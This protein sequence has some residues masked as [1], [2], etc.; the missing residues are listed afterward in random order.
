MNGYANVES[1]SPKAGAKSVTPILVSH[2]TK[3][4]A[5]A[6]P[7]P[8]TVKSPTTPTTP[9]SPASPPAGDI[10]ACVNNEVEQC[11]LRLTDR[12]DHSLLL[13]SRSNTST[14]DINVQEHVRLVGAQFIFGLKKFE[15]T[16]LS[17]FN[18]FSVLCI[19]SELCVLS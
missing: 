7:V 2:T 18:L 15:F 17:I 13:P 11:I 5:S 14:F 10:V 8:I 4:Q 9:L 16:L 12:C 1:P 19:K 6:S 3:Q